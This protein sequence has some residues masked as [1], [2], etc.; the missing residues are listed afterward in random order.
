MPSKHYWIRKR[1]DVLLNG[2]EDRPKPPPTDRVITS[3]GDFSQGAEP[4]VKVNFFGI[5]NL[6]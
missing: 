3:L 5:S 6:I 4:R 2:Y 1:I